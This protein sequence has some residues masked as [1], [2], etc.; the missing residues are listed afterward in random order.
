MHAIYASHYMPEILK[1]RKLCQLA[2]VKHWTILIVQCFA[3]VKLCA[4]SGLWEFFLILVY[5][6]F[7]KKK[8]NVYYK[9][10]LTWLD[11]SA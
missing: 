2:I 5:T 3:T 8:K 11:R 1:Y 6:F 10:N 9:C 4:L 7:C